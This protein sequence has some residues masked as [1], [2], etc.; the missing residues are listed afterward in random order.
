MGFIIPYLGEVGDTAF[1]APTLF[2]EL[3]QVPEHVLRH[4]RYRNAPPSG[5]AAD[6]R[7]QYVEGVDIHRCWRQYRLVVTHVRSVI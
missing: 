5:P 6:R 4:D 1:R 2:R 7:L 3:S